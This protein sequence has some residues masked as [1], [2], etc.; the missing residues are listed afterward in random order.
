MKFLPYI[1]KHLKKN[2]IRTL[3]TIFAMALCIFLISSLQ[4]LLKAFYGG[5][6]NASTERLRDAQ[7][8]E[9]HFPAPA[10]V[11]GADCRHAGHQA[12]REVELVPGRARHQRRHEG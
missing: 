5:L 9:P 6:D 8:R 10:G 12:R 3:S 2:W 11:R 4:T 1:L 7:P